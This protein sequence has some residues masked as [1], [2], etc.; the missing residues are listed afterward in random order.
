MDNG[1]K[2]R[3]L[4]FTT[5]RRASKKLPIADVRRISGAPKL[6]LRQGLC[7]KNDTTTIYQHI[8]N[9]VH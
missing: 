9:G 6:T 5:V 8:A 7:D 1:Q 3:D 4:L 2:L